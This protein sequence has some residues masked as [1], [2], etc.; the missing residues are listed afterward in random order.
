MT[1]NSGKKQ[2]YADYSIIP[3]L[4]FFAP[5]TI[6]WLLV[7]HRSIGVAAQALQHGTSCDLVNAWILPVTQLILDI[8]CYK[9]WG[10]DSLVP[11]REIRGTRL[12][13]GT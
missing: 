4:S 2:R 10:W 8:V 12:G 5:L 3:G 6:P 11:C 1:I 9:I 7:E 13:L